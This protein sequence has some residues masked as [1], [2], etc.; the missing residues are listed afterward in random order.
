MKAKIY[1][2]DGTIIDVV[3]EN[4][5]DFQLDELQKI[6]GGYIEIVGLLDNE[7]MVINEEGKLADLP[8][9][10]NATEIYNEV[11][12]FYDYIVGDVLVC[13]SSM[14]L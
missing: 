12:G 9:N 6:V 8:V 10:E 7:I 4:G 3:P 5:T 14:V 1:K 11:D 2:A 13:D